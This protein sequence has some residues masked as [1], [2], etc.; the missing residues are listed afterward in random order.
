MM[1]NKKCKKCLIEFLPKKS[2]QE[3][4]S[5]TCSNSVNRKAKRTLEQEKDFFWENVKKTEN[6]WEWIGS[7]QKF[8]GKEGYG[9]VNYYGKRQLAHRV[10]WQIHFGEIGNLFVC[11]KCDNCICVRPDHLFLGTNKDNM[12]DCKKKNRFSSGEKH[13]LAILKGL[14]KNSN[15]VL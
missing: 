12:E 3:F 11:H 5:K 10:S 13:R 15:I 9:R 8:N 7:K 14:L 2:K 4:C 6:C 1:N